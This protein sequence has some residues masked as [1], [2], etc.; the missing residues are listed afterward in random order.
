MIKTKDDVLSWL[1]CFSLAATCRSITSYTL[2]EWE[3]SYTSVLHESLCPW[4]LI[5]LVNLHMMHLGTQHLFMYMSHWC[6]DLSCVTVLLLYSIRHEISLP[7]HYYY[8][9]LIDAYTLHWS[10]MVTLACMF[11][12]P[13]PSYCITACGHTLYG[14]V[15]KLPFF[16]PDMA[17]TAEYSYYFV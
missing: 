1:W 7:L 4:A 3:F 16:W 6:M 14:L 10:R 11:S 8:Y 13:L 17:I 15:C 9:V 12:N 5:F 2:W